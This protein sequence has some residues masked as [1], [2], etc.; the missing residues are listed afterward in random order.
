MPTVTKMC[1]LALTLP[2]L[3]ARRHGL[4]IFITGAACPGRT[5]PGTRPTGQRAAT[6][7]RDKDTTSSL[8]FIIISI[9]TEVY[10]LPS[11]E[12][13][14]LI[15]HQNLQSMPLCLDAYPSWLIP[16]SGGPEYINHV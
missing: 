11:F 2:V 10:S 7:S 14:S 3:V 13:F 16:D 6:A 5:G 1:S 15:Q 12:G 4:G 8:W 9:T